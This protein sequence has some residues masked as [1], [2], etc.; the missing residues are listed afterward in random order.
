MPLAPVRVNLRWGAS[1]GALRRAT[2]TAVRLQKHTDDVYAT[3]G[4]L[5][6]VCVWSWWRFVC[7]AAGKRGGG[8]RCA[9]FADTLGA[10]GMTRFF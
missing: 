2:L 8:L 3:H 4:T 7:G 6:G 1:S 5:T 10:D 9:P